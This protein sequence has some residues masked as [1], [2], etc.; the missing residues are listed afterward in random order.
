MKRTVFLTVIL[1]LSYGLA[2]A[3]VGVTA[4]FYPLAHFAR[5]VGGDLVQVTNVTPTGVEPHEFEPRPMDIKNAFASR[6]FI[7]NGGGLDPWAQKLQGD[8]QTKGVT[9]LCMACQ[10]N[11]HTDPH[12]WLDP[13]LAIEE[14][15]LIRDNLS[16]LDPQNETTYKK[17]S[18]EYIKKLTTLDS[19]FRE[20]LKTCQHHEIVV[21]HNAFSYLAQRYNL[22]T[23]PLAG[24]SSIDEP[25]A[26]TLGQISRLVKTKG[27]RYIFFE[28][29]V[30]PR[31]AQ[32]LAS[33]TGAVTLPLNPC[34]GLTT[35]DVRNGKD[36]IAIMQDNL[37]NLRLALSCK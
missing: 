14:V 36:Y 15:R 2:M 5:Q 37:K 7:F 32:A 35:E 20:G 23:I 11:K 18:D 13:V 33:E 29:L 12:F 31:I 27:I 34:E 19:N 3:E 16:K 21:T 4:S 10:L 9:T 30:S 22:K 26:H 1:L 25:S 6:L 8:L 17:N 24:I 28:S